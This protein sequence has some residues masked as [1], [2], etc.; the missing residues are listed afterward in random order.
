MTR[1]SIIERVI[2]E[3]DVPD[4]LPRDEWEEFWASVED[5]EN[6]IADVTEQGI[7]EVQGY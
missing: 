7:E 3:I 2:Y 5:P 6:Y 1:I 4:D